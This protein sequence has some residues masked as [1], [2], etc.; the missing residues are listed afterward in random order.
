MTDK[1][2]NITNKVV[3]SNEDIPTILF[4]KH[5]SMGGGFFSD[6]TP[7]E[8]GGCGIPIPEH[9]AIYNKCKKEGIEFYWNF[10]TPDLSKNKEDEKVRLS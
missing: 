5:P 1:N 8:Y 2:S 9:E 7:F 10:W 3:V 6:A 4:M